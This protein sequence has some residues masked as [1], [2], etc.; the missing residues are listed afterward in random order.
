MEES[1][2]LFIGQ[3]TESDLVFLLISYVVTHVYCFINLKK[4]NHEL[5]DLN[6]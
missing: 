3:V 6:F 1:K 5:T 4:K 2:W